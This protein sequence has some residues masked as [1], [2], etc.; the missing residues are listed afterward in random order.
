[1]GRIRK[2][3]YGG[4]V[5]VLVVA[6]LA[7]C[8]AEQLAGLDKAV[9]DANQVAA[10]VSQIG[11]GPAGAVMPGWVRACLEA[12]GIVGAL[13]VVTWQQLRKSG[14]LEK[15][16]TLTS[17]SK[18]IVRGVDEAAKTDPEAVAKVKAEIQAEMQRKGI[19]PEARQTVRD[20]KAA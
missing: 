7:G 6:M 12:I 16:A 1:M 2:S 19:E 11:A 10:G 5:A 4:L 17:T 15:L 14:L 3:S 20:L 8:T 13:A 9:N 18:A